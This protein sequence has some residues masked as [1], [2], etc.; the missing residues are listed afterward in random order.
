MNIDALVLTT[1]GLVFLLRLSI[2]DFIMRRIDAKIDGYQTNEDILTYSVYEVN[3]GKYLFKLVSE[4]ILIFI[5]VT[6]II[7]GWN[8]LLKLFLVM[9]IAF[10]LVFMRLTLR[11]T[12]K[13]IVIDN[14]ILQVYKRKEIEHKFDLNDVVLVGLKKLFL[15]NYI[16][17][18]YLEFKDGE[19]FYVNPNYQHW[20]QI[21]KIAKDIIN[22]S[23]RN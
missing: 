5:A 9:M 21:V 16:F 6:I 10:L 14:Y 2:P 7:F 1:F 3:Y 15:G 4:I 22:Y 13:K 19:R 23:I 18:Y 12:N 11:V 17:C 20:H 8:L